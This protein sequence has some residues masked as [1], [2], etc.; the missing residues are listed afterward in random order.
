MGFA[1]TRF[2]LQHAIG[3]NFGYDPVLIHL[4]G[5]EFAVRCGGDVFSPR[6]GIDPELIKGKHHFITDVELLFY[7]STLAFLGPTLQA[8]PNQSNPEGQTLVWSTDFWRLQ[9]PTRTPYPTYY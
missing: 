5:I 1:A 7:H 4:I 2:D 9:P 8:Q 6:P 3:A